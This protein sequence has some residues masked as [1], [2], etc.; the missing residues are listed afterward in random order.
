MH[1][2]ACARVQAAL[3][4]ER[5]EID[6]WAYHTLFSWLKL[7]HIRDTRTQ[8]D[9]ISSIRAFINQHQAL[10][11]S[12]VE[13]IASAMLIETI[14]DAIEANHRHIALNACFDRDRLVVLS[15]CSNSF[16][17][18]LITKAS[19][20][21]I[22]FPELWVQERPYLKKK[23][24]KSVEYGPGKY[25][26]NDVLS[27]SK[28]DTVSLQF[29]SDRQ[30]QEQHWKQKDDAASLCSALASFAARSSVKRINWKLFI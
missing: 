9:A 11:R 19:K 24:L 13:S 25:G 12:F 23:K 29:F 6:Q 15:T 30:Y 3:G 26:W 2:E 7:F 1:R 14:Q 8:T 22:C 20:L 28:W 18:F 17:F 10:A 4:R 16:F 5:N 27:C 21:K